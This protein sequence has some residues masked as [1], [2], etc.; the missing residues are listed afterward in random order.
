MTRSLEAQLPGLLAAHSLD[1]TRIVPKDRPKIDDRRD[2]TLFLGAVRATVT[3]RLSFKTVA[4]AASQP[5]IFGDLPVPRDI[6][7]EPHSLAHMHN[8]T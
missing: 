2:V 8:R 7:L 1:D 4:P 5:Y 3:G 6:P